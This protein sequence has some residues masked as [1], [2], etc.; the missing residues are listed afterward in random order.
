MNELPS[1]VLMNI[2]SRVPG[3]SIARFRCV[4]KLWESIL[5]HPDFSEF[6]L[7]TSHTRPP[8]LFFTLEDKDNFF[9]FSSPHP[10]HDENASS[11]VPSRY[12]I[13]H[14]NTPTTLTAYLASPLCGFICHR[15][16]GS[17]DSLV[18]CNPLTGESI[19]L[20]KVSLKSN[21][22]QTRPYLGYDPIEKQL[23][24]L[25]IKSDNLPY[26]CDEHQVLTL[27]ENGKRLW[28]TLQC[29]PHYPISDGICIDGSLYYTAGF[30][31]R[32]RVYVIVCFDVRSEEFS[33]INIDESILM[34]TSCTLINYKGKLGAL[35]FTSFSPKRFEL[36]VL[37]D[38]EKH[39]WS[40]GI[41]TLPPLQKNI[42]K[43]TQLVIV[44]MTGGGEVVLAPACLVDG[45]YVYYFNL[46]FKSLSGVD[47][48]GFGISKRTRVYTSLDYAENLKLMSQ[49]IFSARDAVS[50]RVCH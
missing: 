6:Y 1:D 14:K 21:N 28:R 24:V 3:K 9:F 40:R 39:V 27:A 44:G 26:R 11:L 13:H 35:R 46:E 20:P 47:I 30:A 33:F 19:P 36:L 25:C 8:L 2:F 50:S 31:M 34:T 37:Q 22:T 48:Q 15:D 17:H 10:P 42:E 32:T 18:V 4:S 5:N 7:A 23:K 43:K 29:K 16:W 12:H 49:H 45:F 38:A 41:Y